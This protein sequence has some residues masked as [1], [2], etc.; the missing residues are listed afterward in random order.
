MSILVVEDTAEIRE[1]LGLIL[2]L[3]GFDVCEAADGIEALEK[4]TRSP[5][6]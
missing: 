3:E 2:R 5:R 1:N 6:S 4:S